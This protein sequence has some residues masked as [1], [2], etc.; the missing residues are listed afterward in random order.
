ME[1]LVRQRVFAL[2]LGYEDINDHDDLRRDRALAQC[3][4]IRLRLPMIGARVT[5]S[6][7]RVRL[8]CSDSHP[9]QALFRAAAL[10]IATIPMRC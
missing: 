8:H 2:A 4:S 1:Q 3:D 10:R 6:M 9:G 7:W 5:V